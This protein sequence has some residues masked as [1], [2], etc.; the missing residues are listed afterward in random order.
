MLPLL[1]SELIRCFSTFAERGGDIPVYAVASSN[2][3][4]KFTSI[5]SL[6][7]AL[8]R[9]AMQ[10]LTVTATTS[11]PSLFVSGPA[12]FMQAY[13]SFDQHQSQ[14]KWFRTLFIGFSRYLWFVHADLIDT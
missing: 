8:L 5:L 3:L 2:V 12:G 1:N 11:S 13:R 6:P 9:H 4:L 7:F 14:R 10:R